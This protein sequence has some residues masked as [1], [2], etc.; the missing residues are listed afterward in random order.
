MDIKQIKNL[1]ARY[2]DDVYP[3]F[4]IYFWSWKQWVMLWD[5]EEEDVVELK[6]LEIIP[7]E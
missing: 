7:F 1:K 2:K 5:Y 6:S 3:I 4:A